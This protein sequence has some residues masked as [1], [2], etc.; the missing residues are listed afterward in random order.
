MK[1]LLL[2]LLVLFGL[3][4]CSDKSLLSKVP[5]D[6]DWAGFLDFKELAVQALD[7]AV[8][9][10]GGEKQNGKDEPEW[11]KSGIDFLLK[12][13]V[14]SEGREAGQ[15][16]RLLL[17]LNKQ[18]D[19]EQFCKQQGKFQADSEL[20]QNWLK[21]GN[22]RIFLED[23]LAIV[24][25]PSDIIDAEDYRKAKDNIDNQ[26]E[27]SS[28]LKKSDSFRELCE[29]GKSIGIWA[30]LE[31]SLSKYSYYLPSDFFRGEFAGSLDFRSGE[32]VLDAGIRTADSSAS[33]DFLGQ[34]LSRDFI[35]T[36]VGNADSPGLLAISL[37]LPPLLQALESFGYSQAGSIL[38]A[39][40]G[41]QPEEI[42][43]TLSGQMALSAEAMAG[44]KD[45][46]PDFR[47]VIGLQKPADDV[48]AK[49]ALAG[50]ISAQGE[51]QYSMTGI[52]GFLLR[53]NEKLLEISAAE[54]ASKSKADEEL[55][56]FANQE[57][58]HLLGNLNLD[59]MENTIPDAE[60]SASLTFLK[61]YWKSLRLRF[62]K[63]APGKQRLS[64]HLQCRDEDDNSLKVLAECLRNIPARIQAK[65]RIS[66]NPPEP[67]F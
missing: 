17:P 9:F 10:S 24:L 16:T 37:S 61:K 20:G 51:N 34:A 21:K 66:E 3:S 49:L 46:I 30:N 33:A 41:I 6:A 22:V 31:P 26:K 40:Y 39:Q 18:E 23:K 42:L 5:E 7:P 11:E 4:S 57:P 35:E 48:L 12:A 8:L 59:A 44:R 19:F 2:G 53:K 56:S 45:G 60:I 15:I 14:F 43:E 63:T 62:A 32:L 28:L 29:E 27:E 65:E 52:P 47:L 54:A 38:L 50:L 36:S 1:N 25:L 55:L 58:A 67:L 13:V 64:V